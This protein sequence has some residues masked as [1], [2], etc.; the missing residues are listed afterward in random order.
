MKTPATARIEYILYLAASFLVSLLPRPALLKLGTWL[1]RLFYRVDKRHRELARRNLRETLGSDEIAPKVF[2]HF[3]RIA[4]D[5]IKLWDRKPEWIAKNVQVEG[6][7]Y[8]REALARG[9]VVLFTAHYGNWELGAIHTAIL[10]GPLVVIAHALDNRILEKYLRVKR[11]KLG[12]QVVE[13]RESARPVLRALQSGR[14]VAILIDQRVSA[15][16]G[17]AVNFLGRPALSTP[18]AA[19][20]ALQTDARRTSG[21]IRCLE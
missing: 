11:E 8:V 4:L 3:G 9:G 5:S 2:E 16:E 17:L 10:F 13:K 12:N 21:R 15:K 14:I 19:R 20:L 18:A 7:E 6:A 1:G